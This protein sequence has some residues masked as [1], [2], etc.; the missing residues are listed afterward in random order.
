[1]ESTKVIQLKNNFST[2]LQNRGK[3][4]EDTERTFGLLKDEGSFE[5]KKDFS[6]TDE[7]LIGLKVLK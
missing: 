7:E 2:I 6:M 1:M 4:K 5:I 3:S